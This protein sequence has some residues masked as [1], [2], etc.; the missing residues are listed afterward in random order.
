M[1]A[2]VDEN[3][4]SYLDLTGIVDGQWHSDVG[5]G[6]EPMLEQFFHQPTYLGVEGHQLIEFMTQLGTAHAFYAELACLWVGLEIDV[7][8]VVESFKNVHCILILLMGCFNQLISKAVEPTLYAGL[9]AAYIMPSNGELACNGG[10]R[11]GF[12][13]ITH[14]VA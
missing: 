14:H 1:E 7:F 10:F 3:A 4:L 11:I 13:D 2:I 8:S 5:S 12:L 9:S 6:R